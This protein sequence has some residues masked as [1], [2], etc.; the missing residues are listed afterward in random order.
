MRI[1]LIATKILTTHFW[2]NIGKIRQNLKAVSNKKRIN[3]Y[4]LTK[5]KSA[6]MCENVY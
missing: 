3:E 6:K 2:L 1:V 5:L 4:Y